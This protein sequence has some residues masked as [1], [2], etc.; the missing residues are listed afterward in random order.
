MIDFLEYC[1]PSEEQKKLC[2]YTIFVSCFFNIV[3]FVVF[4]FFYDK[5]KDDLIPAAYP[6]P[7]G[8]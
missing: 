6:T 2:I 8:A 7:G 3:F 1:L 4:Q 5:K